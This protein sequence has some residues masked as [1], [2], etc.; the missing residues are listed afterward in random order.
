MQELWYGLLVAALWGTVPII[1]K[2]IFVHRNPPY[3]VIL[4]ISCIVYITS[5]I[6]WVLMTRSVDVVIHDV[7]LL[8]W[9]NVLILCTTSFFALFIGNIIYLHTVKH[10]NNLTIFVLLTSMYPII[11]M[12]LAWLLLK[13][14]MT[15]SFIGGF[16]LVMTGVWIMILS[17]KTT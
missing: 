4:L 13:E 14:G 1:H 7:K 5:V 6:A 10:T 2:H 12:I 9:K 15:W 16:M 17:K 3:Y 11:T 8:G